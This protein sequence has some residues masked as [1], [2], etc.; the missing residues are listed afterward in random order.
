MAFAVRTI[1]VMLID[2]ILN[3]KTSLDFNPDPFPEPKIIQ[4][5][6]FHK[7]I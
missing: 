1:L 5:A 2:S 6:L 3:N 7:V 4:N